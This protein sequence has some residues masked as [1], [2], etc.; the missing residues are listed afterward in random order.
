VLQKICGR[1]ATLPASYQAL[2]GV[3]LSTGETPV[4]FGGF[5]DVYK[6]MLDTGAWVCVK[7][8]R[9][10]ASDNVDQVKQAGR[11]FNLLWVLVDG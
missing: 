8:I 5:S 4:A 2:G 11:P 7:K 3:L 6:G 9:V 10:H 1:R